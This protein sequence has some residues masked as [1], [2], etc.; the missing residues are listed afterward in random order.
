MYRSLAV[1]ISILS[2]VALPAQARDLNHKLKGDYA[3][4]VTSLCAQTQGGFGA[5]G[6]AIGPVTLLHRIVETTRSYDGE[7]GLTI[8]GRAFQ[9]SAAA[10]FP[11][12][13]SEFTCTGTYQV[14]ENNSFSESNTCAGTVVTG[15]VA[16]Q[17]FTQSA[18]ATDGHVRGKTI[19]I[20]ETH[21]QPPTVVT[22]SAAGAFFRLCGS[23]GMGVK[24]PQD[25]D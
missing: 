16:G 3:T 21:A 25:N 1:S 18:A 9:M 7:G 4:S 17:T 20:A 8:T 6:Q 10:P 19:V 24:I 12:T 5:E 11:T 13:E 22:L 2:I 23:S 15:T 14:G